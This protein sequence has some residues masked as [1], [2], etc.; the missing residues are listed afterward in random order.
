MA[1]DEGNARF[2]VDRG[3]VSVERS[4]SRTHGVLEDLLVVAATPRYN[5]THCSL[6]SYIS[7]TRSVNFT[8]ISRVIL[9]RRVP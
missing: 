1:E 4:R 5:L 9:A 2:R 8:G 6:L 7:E 3:G